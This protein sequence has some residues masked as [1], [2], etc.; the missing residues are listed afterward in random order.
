MIEPVKIVL[1]ERKE[2]HPLVTLAAPDAAQLPAVEK[3][4]SH[5]SR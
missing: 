4:G 5:I 2:K 3:H 1:F